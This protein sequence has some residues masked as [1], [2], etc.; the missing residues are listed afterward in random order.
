MHSIHVYFY[1]KYIFSLVLPFWKLFASYWFFTLSEMMN[2]E[3]LY[4]FLGN[5]TTYINDIY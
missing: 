3:L 1:V 4:I 2:M 5:T